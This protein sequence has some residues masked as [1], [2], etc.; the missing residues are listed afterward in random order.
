ML[1]TVRDRRTRDVI[2]LEEESEAELQQ[3]IQKTLSGAVDELILSDDGKQVKLCDVWRNLPDRDSVCVLAG[4]SFSSGGCC[5][6]AVLS[7][8]SGQ[9]AVC[10]RALRRRVMYS[11][12]IIYLSMM[13]TLI[14]QSE[15][16]VGFYASTDLEQ[17][18]RELQHLHTFTSGSVSLLTL[19]YLYIY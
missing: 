7:F 12:W 17:T 9:R 3:K 16:A 5:Y 6:D 1:C 14:L 8:R 2:P 10:H 11:Y 19:Y 4:Q 13:L 15:A 18:P